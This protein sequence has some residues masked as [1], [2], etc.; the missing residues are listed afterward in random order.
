MTCAGIDDSRSNAKLHRKAAQSMR[1]L[2]ACRIELFIARARGA[3]T[4][5]QLASFRHRLLWTASNLAERPASQNLL[6]L[7]D[8]STRHGSATRTSSQYRHPHCIGR[9]ERLGCRW[10]ER[11]AP[12][13][14]LVHL[15]H[16]LS[17]FPSRA[18][19]WH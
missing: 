3:A 2:K 19:G 10:L 1:D 9:D 5:V 18:A 6:S 7:T 13:E 11:A 14:Q 4:F 12:V 15:Q 17:R 8:A 16:F